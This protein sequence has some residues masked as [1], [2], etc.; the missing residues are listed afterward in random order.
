MDR[1]ILTLAREEEV[2]LLA[3]LRS[4][5]VFQR[6]EAIRSVI[7]SYQNEHVAEQV[8]HSVDRNPPASRTAAV[9]RRGPRPNSKSAEIIEASEA[10]LNK[11]GH[12]AESSVIA[13]EIQRLGISVPGEKPISVVASYLS[14]SPKFDNVRG[15]GYGLTIWSKGTPETQTAASDQ[16]TAV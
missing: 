12:R 10:F 13:N 1:D 6:L 3:E 4:N 7:R 16:E 11:L 15:E 5:P 14:N 8:P 2:K 9:R